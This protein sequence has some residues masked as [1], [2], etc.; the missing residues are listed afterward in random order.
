MQVFKR[1]ANSLPTSVRTLKTAAARCPRLAYTKWLADIDSTVS[2]ATHHSS[3]GSSVSRLRS[4]PRCS[5]VV[6]RSGEAE[7]WRNGDVN[8]R[9]ADFPPSIF[10]DLDDDD[11]DNLSPSRSTHR[12]SLTGRSESDGRFP[13]EMSTTIVCLDDDD[14]GGGDSCG[15]APTKR[16]TSTRRQ[17]TTRRRKN[18]AFVGSQRI[19]TRASIANSFKHNN[20][21][22]VDD[23][24]ETLTALFSDDRRRQTTLSTGRQSGTEPGVGSDEINAV[25]VDGGKTDSCLPEVITA[26]GDDT[27]VKESTEPAT[28]LFPFLSTLGDDDAEWW[29]TPEMFG[30]RGTTEPTSTVNRLM[31]TMMTSRRR[32]NNANTIAADRQACDD[33][34]RMI[35]ALIREAATSK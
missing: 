5:R 18:G 10:V 13:H 35:A 6:G 27:V 9:M 17:K 26:G 20:C 19:V 1:D 24:D 11:E 3:S 33:I 16:I 34:E 22:V 23:A 2:A 8:R 32:R 15:G 14:D 25:A 21:P 28:K 30:W 31:T 12:R 7:A 29:T 4:R